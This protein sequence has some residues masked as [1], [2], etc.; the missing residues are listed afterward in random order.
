MD[1]E[2]SVASKFGSMYCIY[3]KYN[4]L[5]HGSLEVSV[6]DININGHV[7]HNQKC[8]PITPLIQSDSY[9]HDPAHKET[10]SSSNRPMGSG[11][12]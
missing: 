2:L 3:S 7:L 8:F 1:S 12:I 4:S 10:S 9:S 11:P 5:F 6:D